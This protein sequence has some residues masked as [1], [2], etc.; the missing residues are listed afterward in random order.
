MWKGWERSAIYG[1][2]TVCQAPYCRCLKTDKSCAFVVFTKDGA[3]FSL[4]LVLWRV[5]LPLCLSSL[6][7]GEESLSSAHLLWHSLYL[8]WLQYLICVLDK[9]LSRHLHSPFL[10]FLYLLGM[11]LILLYKITVMAEILAQW[12]R[13]WIPLLLKGNKW[14]S[15]L[16]SVM[17]SLDWF[18][19]LLTSGLW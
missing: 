6:C 5:C 19:F 14:K 10:H 3:L 12:S 15:K 13:A 2:P 7:S 1:V 9:G 17:T 4:Q 18:M 16:V 11:K 8:F